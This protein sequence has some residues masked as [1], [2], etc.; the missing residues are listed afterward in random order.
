MYYAH[1]IKCQFINVNIVSMGTYRRLRNKRGYLHR[2]FSKYD[3]SEKSVNFESDFK[4][5]PDGFE[6]PNSKKMQSKHTYFTMVFA[7]IFSI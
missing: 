4:G 1:N 6:A 7:F 2:T 3:I 5:V